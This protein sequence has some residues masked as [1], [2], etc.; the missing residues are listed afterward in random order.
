M[1]V[2]WCLHLLSYLDI[3]LQVVEVALLEDEAKSILEMDNYECRDEPVEE[4]EQAQQ[5]DNLARAEE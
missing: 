1:I 2:F 4:H 5:P 3:D